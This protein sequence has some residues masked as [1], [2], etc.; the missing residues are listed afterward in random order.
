MLYMNRVEVIGN[1]TRDPELRFT[2]NNQAVANFAVATNRRT[3][4]QAGNWTD[5]PPEYHEVV[6]WG[7]LGERCNQVLHKGDRVFVSGRLQTRSW[8]APDGT[9]K[10][11]TELIAD[12]LIGPDQV[13]KS[14]SSGMDG[15][16]NNAPAASEDAAAPAK[17][18]GKPAES[19]EEEI[20]I[21]DI[22]F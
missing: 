20:N 5:A 18:G 21:E 15:I 10:Y 11:R 12:S 7:Q 19:D 1:L 6:V 16:N 8:E 3:K 4:D 22:P 17:K 14:L 2:A 9:K 13:N